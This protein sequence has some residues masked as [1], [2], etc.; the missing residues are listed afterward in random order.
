METKNILLILGALGFTV[1]QV[2]LS[3]KWPKCKEQTDL[4]DYY[5]E[6]FERNAQNS[7]VKRQVRA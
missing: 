3:A 1:I 4:L 2:T 5:A 7:V 6:I